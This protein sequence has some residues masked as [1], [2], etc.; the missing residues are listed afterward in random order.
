MRVRAQL[1]SDRSLVTNADNASS[2]KLVTEPENVDEYS[3]DDDWVRG[4]FAGLRRNRNRHEH[5][6]HDGGFY[7]HVHSGGDTAHAHT[8]RTK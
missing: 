2:V 5:A 7:Y 4:T 1:S 3:G 8:L 6:H